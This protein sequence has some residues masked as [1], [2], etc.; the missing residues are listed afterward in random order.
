[1][2]GATPTKSLAN[3][4]ER[5]Q[6]LKF[7]ADIDIEKEK[8]IDIVIEIVPDI[9]TVPERDKETVSVSAFF[10]SRFFHS[11][12]PSCEAYHPCSALP[13]REGARNTTAASGG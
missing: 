8:E 12:F 11:P 1:L 7:V 5:Y 4:G 3:A 13:N 9:D 6:T 10:A 2:R